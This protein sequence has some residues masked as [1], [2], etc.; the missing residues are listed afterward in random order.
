MPKNIVE[1]KIENGID[2]R[3]CNQCLKFKTLD[4][5][6][7]NCKNNPNWIDSV[8]KC[9][10]K[11][12]ST[13]R[14]VE[15]REDINAK[16]RQKIL[17]KNGLKS[18]F[19]YIGNKY[20]LLKDIKNLLPQNINTFIDL[21]CGSTT[22]SINVEANKYI[23]NDSD[24]NVINFLNKCKE[25]NSDEI[26]NRV[27]SIIDKF[28]A[29]TEDGYMKLREYFNEGNN[30]WDIYYALLCNSFNQHLLYNK[31]GKTDTGYGQ[32]VTNFNFILKKRIK[33]YIDRI[34][35]IKIEFKNQGYK[36]LLKKPLEKDDFVFIDPPYLISSVNYFSR[37]NKE[38]EIYLLNKLDELNEN[39]IKF[40]LCN[41]LVNK[42]KT[43]DIL[44]QWRVKYNTTY[45]N[46]DFNRI[47]K[48]HDKENDVVEV[49][50][51]NYTK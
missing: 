8:C 7:S 28:E 48:S 24:E 50:I 25:L 43:N 45:V 40:M 6:Y 32:G 29:N 38:D 46:N 11:D 36:E 17:D 14:Q 33:E 37:W 42:G 39:G 35:N 4:N 19:N 49:L 22:V 30:D 10:R 34:S 27:Q 44:E 16:S 15:F 18:P 51:T 31:K 47:S 12:K 20:S 3:K 5:F 26:C 1:T 2:Y 9:C 41:V 13:K 21:F 23:C